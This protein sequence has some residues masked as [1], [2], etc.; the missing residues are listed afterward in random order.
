MNNS[1]KQLIIFCF[2]IMSS[3][4]LF[5]QNDANE[6]YFE[7]SKT[8]LTDDAYHIFHL[9]LGFVQ[10]PFHL[11]G[12]DLF[13][14]A[15][16]GLATSSLFL[17]DPQIK[18]I[19]HK[20]QT[21]ANDKFFEIDSYFNGRTGSFAA[22]GLYVTGFLFRQ[23]KIR[24]MGLHGLEALFISA[25]ITDFL[26]YSFGR[27]RPYAGEDQMNFKLFRGSKGKYRAFPSGHTTSAFAFASVMAMS[28]D[29]IYWKTAWYGSASMVGLARIYH[30][31]H[32]ISDTFLAA[33]I[34]YNVA[35]FV[36]HFDKDKQGG[37]SFY[38]SINGFEVKISF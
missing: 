30:N 36:V 12:N 35:D 24:V 19:A 4:Y 28:V 18:D 26:K 38:P 6:S 14:G 15:G 27:C 21:A 29:N 13:Y 17:F 8:T 7:Y 10:A 32:W 20:N 37:F 23:E 16:M 2:L 25:A 5:A 22:A 33:L 31:E 34:S 3:H 1:V 11:N 9:G